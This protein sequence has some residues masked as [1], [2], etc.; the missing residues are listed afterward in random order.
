MYHRQELFTELSPEDIKASL[1]ACALVEKDEYI[2]D[3]VY[4]FRECRS[5]I[6]QGKTYKQVAA[7]FRRQDKFKQTTDEL[8]TEAEL[9]DIS[10]LLALARDQGG[11]RISFKEIGSILASCGLSDKD[12]YTTEEGDR[13][14]AAC[15]LIKQQG[16]NYEEVA[17]HFGLSGDKTDDNIEAEVEEAASAL[18]Q[19]GNGVVS[20]VMRHKAKADAS[21]A[22]SLY[23]NHL[24]NEFGSPQFQAAWQQMEG[25]LIAKV[26]GKSRL[27]A[28]QMLGEVQGMPPSSLPSTAL[29]VASED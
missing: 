4:R 6:E 20:E 22:A 14:L 24:A 18:E 25:M 17:V 12:Q 1:N 28:S 15:E 23:L 26:V 13:F 7:H 5:L 27:R 2:E 16:Q 3:E 21:A 19:S 10:E 11:H 9:L 8:K 29:P